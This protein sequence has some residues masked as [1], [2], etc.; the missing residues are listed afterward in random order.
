MEKIYI[1]CVEDQRE[2]L[3]TIASQLAVLDQHVI[4]EECESAQEAQELIEEIDTAGDFIALV[5]SDHVMPG[6]TGVE[7]LTDLYNDGRFGDTKKILLTGQATHMDTI[8]AINQ[9]GIDFYIE[10]PWKA[11]DLLQ[12]VCTLLTIFIIKK[13][14]EYEPF[15]E[16]LDKEKLFNLL[17]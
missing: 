4:I 1:L 12:K 7:L 3:N 17:K 6:K 13:G 8:K 16:I 2:V 14:I 15:L 5:I 11:E 10:K 9:A